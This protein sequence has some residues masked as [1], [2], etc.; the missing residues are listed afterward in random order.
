M[1]R[2]MR[3]LMK[4]ELQHVA[5]LDIKR[6]V[7]ANIWYRYLRLPVVLSYRDLE[8]PRREIDTDLQTATGFRRPESPV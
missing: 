7:L 3:G 2:V 6:S 8:V 1:N 4:I 5:H